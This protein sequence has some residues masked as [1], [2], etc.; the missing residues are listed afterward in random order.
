MTAYSPMKD[1]IWKFTFLGMPVGCPVRV[2]ARSGRS[3]AI[4]ITATLCIDKLCAIWKCIIESRIEANSDFRPHD[5]V[6]NVADHT[7]VN[8]RPLD[9]DRRLVYGGRLL[10][11][12]FCWLWLLG[13]RVRRSVVTS[14][15]FHAAP[16]LGESSVGTVRARSCWG[17]ERSGSSVERRPL[18]R[19]KPSGE[20]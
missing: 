1:R 3:P 6:V 2:P 13:R 4:T 12:I 10:F 19:C 15:S 5:S 7:C 18:Q 16:A 11:L 8:R 20:P 9:F 17:F 14:H